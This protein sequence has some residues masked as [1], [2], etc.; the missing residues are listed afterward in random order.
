MTLCLTWKNNNDI[1]FA[2]DSRITRRA[3]LDYIVTSNTAPKI[4]SIPIRIY[5]ADLK[6]YYDKDWVFCLAGGYISATGY[7]DTLSEVLSNLQIA[8]PFSDVDYLKILNIAF[9]I[10]EQIGK[11][12]VETGN[13]E[14][15]AKILITGVCPKDSK[16]NFVYEFGYQ[17]QYHGITYYSKEIDLDEY[18]MHFI[19]DDTAI[20]Y[21]KEKLQKHHAKHY[22]K[23]LKEICNN[24]DFPTVG[25]HLQAGILKLDAPK[26]FSIYGILESELEMDNN[27]FWTVKDNWFF[28]S[29]Q[30]KPELFEGNIHVRKAFLMPFDSERNALFDEANNRNE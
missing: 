4:F 29:I 9:N 18:E 6:L 16:R 26:H 22:F 11:Q 21:F 17:V 10:Y 30:L 20:E 23:L 3:Y 15:L 14:A 13:R 7:A 8:D 19:G 24:E 1:Y 28:R 27:N 5:S 2:S 12:L 25:G